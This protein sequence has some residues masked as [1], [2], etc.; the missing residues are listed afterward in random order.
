[1]REEVKCAGVERICGTCEV[2]GG[3]KC[4]VIL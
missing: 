2:M 1:M 4:M 3:H